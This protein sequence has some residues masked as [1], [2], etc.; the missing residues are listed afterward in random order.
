MIFRSANRKSATQWN[1]KVKTHA[2]RN[3]TER[4]DSKEQKERRA[5]AHSLHNFVSGLSTCIA[6][7]LLPPGSHVALVTA[8][9]ADLCPLL[10]R[11]SCSMLTC[12]TAQ[13]CCCHC[14]L[15]LGG[16]KGVGHTT[17]IHCRMDVRQ[18]T[19]FRHTKWWE[20]WS[21]CTKSIHRGIEE[22]FKCF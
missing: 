2:G 13:R 16:G 8:A 12:P 11:A 17:S 20:C 6:T 14:I 19:L 7:G 18:L 9:S 4:D 5:E 1:W 10:Q 15:Q 21:S 3:G 22:Y